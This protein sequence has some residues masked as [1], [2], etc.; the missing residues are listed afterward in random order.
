MSNGNAPQKVTSFSDMVTICEPLLTKHLALVDGVPCI[1]RNRLVPKK[2]PVKEWRPIGDGE[3]GELR[4]LTESRFKELGYKPQITKNNMADVAAYI[5]QY[6]ELEICSAL[7]TIKGIKWDGN[8][9]LCYLPD[10]L[11]WHAPD[12]MDP[13]MEEVYLRF[14]VDVLFLAPIQRMRQPTTVDFVPILVGR[15]GVGKSRFLRSIANIDFDVNPANPKQYSMI[16][17]VHSLAGRELRDSVFSQSTGKM[18]VEWAEC[19]QILTRDN[20]PR[21]KAIIDQA[22]YTYREPYARTVTEHPIYCATVFTTNVQSVLTDVENR[23][24]LPVD[25]R[26]GDF[27][28]DDVEF[29]RQMWA[30]AYFRVVELG[31]TYRDLI[32]DNPKLQEFCDKVTSAHTDLPTDVE[33]YLNF[34]KDLLDNPYNCGSMPWAD[35][36]GQFANRFPQ[37]Y[38]KAQSQT[39]HRKVKQFAFRYG[40]VVRKV[41]HHILMGNNGKKM[42]VGQ[43]WGLCLADQEIDETDS[44]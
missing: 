31:D 22:Q 14:V 3:L 29:V 38:N 4:I 40:M 20:E 15:Q 2:P 32:T 9:R 27:P 12:G 43:S 39:L 23:R 42:S 19:D 24:Y 13:E 7:E 26:G 44:E 35:L 16:A 41:T 33:A 18:V 36:D 21:M 6:P 34:A 10:M 1:C 17:G 25:M 37:Y 30:E 11:G 28:Y 8:S 5:V